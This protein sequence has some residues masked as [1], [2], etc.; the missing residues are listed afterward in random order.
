MDS[1]AVDRWDSLL[2]VV[3]QGLMK[4]VILLPCTKTITAEQ[5]ATLLL[6][7]LY[8]QF[9]LLDKIIS[10]QG[11]QFTS[12]SFKELLKLLGIK[13]ALLMAYH[14]QT[15]GTTEQVNQEIKAYLSIYCASHPEEWLDAI[16]ILEFTHNNWW[17]ADQL[18]TP[19]E[20]LY[21]ESPVAIPTTLKHTKYPSI[22]ERINGMIKDRE[23]ALAAHELAQR[24]I[25]ERKKNM[26]IPFIK[27]QRVWLNTQNL[28][29]SYHKMTPKQEGPFKI[30]EVI[31]L[32]TYWLKLPKYWKIHNMF[33]VV[34]LKPYMETN[35]H[36][37]NY[38][39]PPPE[40]LEEQEVYEVEMIIK[41]QKQGQGYQYFIKWKGYPIKEAMWEPESKSWKMVT[42]WNNINFNINF[43][44]N[45][46]NQ[47]ASHPL[48]L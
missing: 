27:G 42:C 24:R 12:Q 1:P 45:H 17:H 11:P 15:D 16:P 5:V 20:L 37:E 8:K 25:V 39:Q 22:E 44:T 2:V 46:K 32:V 35:V 13:L 10:D 18:W 29:T 21:G 3:D 34:L 14:P 47:D 38:T 26:F 31:G 43:K 7:N 28:K 4:G 40:L 30:K 41:H 6:D 19:F 36:G 48:T 23:E 33:H 9:G